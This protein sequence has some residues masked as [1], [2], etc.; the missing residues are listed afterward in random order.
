MPDMVLGGSLMENGLCT[1]RSRA[2]AGQGTQGWGKD[3]SFS[4]EAPIQSVEGSLRSA[5][6]R[7]VLFV[8]S[9]VVSDHIPQP[10][11]VE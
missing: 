9:L 10:G 8:F 7:N 5:R 3:F 1:L 2:G 6:V 4:S 11:G